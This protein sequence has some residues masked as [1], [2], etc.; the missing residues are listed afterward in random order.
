MKLKISHV[1]LAIAI[2]T[3]I[4]G[5]LWR[6]RSKPFSVPQGTTTLSRVQA[7]PLQPTLAWQT[8][9]NHPVPFQNGLPYFSS[10]AQKHPRLILNGT[11]KKR[12]VAANHSLSFMTR[13]P[14]VLRVIEQE[15][16][17]AL[18]TELNAGAWSDHVVPGVENPAPDRYQ[19]A[20]WYRTSFE[21]PPAFKDQRVILH[22]G[23]AHYMADVWVNGQWIGC[24]EGGAT[25][26]SFD[27][28]DVLQSGSNMLTVRVDNPPWRPFPSGDTPST[29]D[30]PTIPYKTAD[31]WNYG[32]ILRDV[33]LEA[34]PTAS[35]FRVDVRSET[36]EARASE[37]A[38]KGIVV[39]GQF[40]HKNGPYELHFKLHRAR[41]TEENLL[42]PFAE[43]LVDPTEIVSTGSSSRTWTPSSETYGVVPFSLTYPNL[44][45]W[46]LR[47][48]KLYVLEVE[49]QS[50]GKILDHFFTQFGVR[51]IARQ[52]TDLTLNRQPVF[53]RGVA[54]H[55]TFPYAFPQ[56]PPIPT[57]L[58]QDF[59]NIYDLN[60]NF[61]RTG[62]R[63]AHPLF[64]LIADRLGIGL[65][66]EIPVYWFEAKAF[67]AQLK[68]P[69]ARQMFSE[70]I[71]RDFNR[72][73][74]LIWGTCNESESQ[75][76]RQ[77]F[78]E[79]LKQ[80]ATKTDG[81]RLVAQSASGN[82][83]FDATHEACDLMG[84]TSYYGV[85]YGHTYGPA[86][87]KALETMHAAHP[88]LPLFATEFGIWSEK[89]LSNSD[90]QVQVAKDTF[91][92]FTSKPYLC[93]CIWW[94]LNDWH[95][96]ITNPQ[97]MGLVT[98]SGM[99][100]PAY[101]TLQQ[102]YASKESPVQ[103]R[104]RSPTSWKPLRGKIDLQA[105]CLSNSPVKSFA[106]T[107]D[108]HDLA[109]T[110][111]PKTGL[112]IAQLDT[113]TLSEGEHSLATRAETEDGTV[114]SETT[115]LFVDN[116]DKQ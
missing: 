13:T 103:L 88:D 86:T 65:W 69:I 75:R 94:A 17:D 78:I 50:N 40:D 63:P 28:T 20:A 54:V 64:P 107:L 55:E 101:S 96:M 22:F 115:S 12:R 18:S 104:W 68:R 11:W 109:V 71:A 14:E 73:S 49:L 42:T 85:F 44:E 98:L 26:F 74:V 24:H 59:Q 80:V 111:D 113:T 56:Q 116:L 51:S 31:W 102:L 45:N 62:H 38:I 77:A 72:P 106:L 100:K 46:N 66:E 110:R 37:T 89:D 5:I 19:D 97:S 32:G 48:P 108:N 93:G 10:D 92:A 83:A 67:E 91:E 47:R 8:L 52:K 33:E 57:G 30:Y 9:E 15:T 23:A 27:V 70:M 34:R 53:F 16:P 61:V 29:T 4:A 79:D 25:P 41:I 36:S 7:L 112:F 84:F 99:R 81:T 58:R 21:T 3:V 60:A 114:F 35:I 82:D 87:I 95:T 90:A 2:P 1:L 105:E 76:E 39:L 6:S 43:D